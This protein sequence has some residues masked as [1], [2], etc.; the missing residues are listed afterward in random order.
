[1]SR[2]LGDVYKRQPLQRDAEPAHEHRAASQAPPAAPTDE[3]KDEAA[4]DGPPTAFSFVM[5][6]ELQRIVRESDQKYKVKERGVFADTPARR[7]GL[8][9]HPA[10][11]RLHKPTELTELMEQQ[12]PM[13]TTVPDAQGSYTDGRLF[14]AMDAV[15]LTG[16]ITP[17]QDTQLYCVLDNG[18]HLSLIHISEPTRHTNASRMPSSA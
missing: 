4:A 1:M 9:T 7:G 10:W 2:G 16:P 3:L 15:T 11:M 13:P 8:G 17:S 14:L 18:I 6:R 5:E 12:P